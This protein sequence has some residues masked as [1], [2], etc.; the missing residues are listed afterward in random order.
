MNM[1]CPVIVS[2]GY[3]ED[4]EAGH[5]EGTENLYFL[6]KPTGRKEF[7]NLIYS[8]LEFSN[9]GRLDE[10]PLLQEPRYPN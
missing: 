6:E 1:E 7:F 4:L 9:R 8:I 5:F 10:F 2:S 3:I